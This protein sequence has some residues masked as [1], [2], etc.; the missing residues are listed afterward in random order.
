MPGPHPYL[1]V[2]DANAAIDFYTRAFG[3]KELARHPAEDGKRLLHAHL[4]LFGGTLFLSD[5]FP[6]L[7]G[8]SVA[9]KPGEHVKSFVLHLGVERDIDNVFQ[10]AID[11]GATVTQPL[12][13]MPWGDRFGRLLDPFGFEWSMGMQLGKKGG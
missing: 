3:A 13:D 11:A 9:P 6:E 2:H 12:A 5:A 7:G 10:R 4:L 1:T 8:I